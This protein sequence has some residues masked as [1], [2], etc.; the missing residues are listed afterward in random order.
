MH[1]FHNHS[2]TMYIVC[3]KYEFVES[4][5]SLKSFYSILSFETFFDQH[6]KL[7]LNN[8]Q[9]ITRLQP[10]VYSLAFTFKENKRIFFLYI[11]WN[12]CIHLLMT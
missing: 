2:R 4:F 11:L 10:I 5:G 6:E 8:K 7:S 9:Q 3:M 12:E 1:F